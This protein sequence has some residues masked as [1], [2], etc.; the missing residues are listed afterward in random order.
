MVEKIVRYKLNDCETHLAEMRR[1]LAEHRAEFVACPY[2][3]DFE[4]EWMAE[5]VRDDIY[6][7]DAGFP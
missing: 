1:E 3:R 7:V 5:Y 2:T 6:L 4:K